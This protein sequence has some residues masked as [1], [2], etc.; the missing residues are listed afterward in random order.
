MDSVV[1]S[2]VLFFDFDN[3]ITQGDVL[4]RVI[5]R[6]SAS[7][8]W[9]EWEAQWQAGSM[10]TRECLQRQVGDLRV[11]LGHRRQS[12]VPDPGP[13][14]ECGGLVRERSIRHR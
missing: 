1:R 10:T 5:E 12:E 7:Q 3:T 9:R 8:S 14:L 13:G 6:Y 2:P 11:A 4:D